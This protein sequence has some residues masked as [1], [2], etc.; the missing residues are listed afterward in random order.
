MVALPTLDD[1]PI[2]SGACHVVY[3]ARVVW[4]QGSEGFLLAQRLQLEGRDAAAAA[5]GG[6]LG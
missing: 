4:L 6:C 2:A 3:C 1:H 5:A